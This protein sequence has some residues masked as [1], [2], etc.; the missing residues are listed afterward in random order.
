M[1]KKLSFSEF[2]IHRI[3]L[4]VEAVL[5]AFAPLLFWSCRSS[6]HAFI[7]I[8][9]FNGASQLLFW[10]MVAVAAAVAVLCALRFRAARFEGEDMPKPYV[11]ACAVTFFATAV[12][13]IASIVVI[14]VMGEESAPVA[15]RGLVRGL[16]VALAYYAVVF[17]SLFFPAVKGKK[18][19]VVIACVAVTLGVL[20]LLF[21]L[22]PP[23]HY[24]FLAAPMVIDDGDGYSVVFATSAPGTGYIEYEYEGEEY[25]VYDSSAGRIKG[26]STIHHIRVPYEHLDN[27]DYRVGSMRVLE[28]YGYGGRNGR[29]ITSE[30]Y[31]FTPVTGEEQD[32][33][34]ISD[35]HIRMSRAHDAVKYVGD[36][37]AVLYM[38]DASPGL[39]WEEEAAEY[40]V[41]FGG[42]LSGGEKPVVYLRGNHETR[43]AYASKLTDALGMESLYYEVRMGDYRFI[44]LDCG[45]D[46]HDD[47]P[48]Y[49]S[50][51]DYE[52]Y[53][54]E[55]ADWLDTLEPDGSKT[56]VLCHAP[57]VALIEGKYVDV[58]ED[59]LRERI[60]TKLEELGASVL[61]SGHLH[62][63][64]LNLN[65][66]REEMIGELYI[67]PDGYTYEEDP[68]TNVGGIPVYVD[69]GYV[70][71]R[72]L[73][74]A[75]KVTLSPDGIALLAFSEHGDKVFEYTLGW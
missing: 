9:S 15:G 46:K 22:Y 57:S 47:H 6:G 45:E 20:G 25:R 17:F 32:Y 52:A 64:Y 42:E 30:T 51:A 66:G 16:P 56:V 36:Y 54:V 50:L 19:R 12:F 40:I 13:F 73:F 44:V 28:V 62:E 48:E 63:C 55:M 7:D 31:T 1:K 33:L 27:N 11:I 14:G 5:A 38:G 24:E 61:I 37:D 59:E 58:G 2:M 60:F 41:K 43:G 35:W 3:T 65:D 23:V 49:G 68:T 29:T 53:R 72:D 75:S 67:N 10:L 26:D 69:G 71:R 21:T 70:H 34:C 39:E 74:V 8:Y 18:P 4:A